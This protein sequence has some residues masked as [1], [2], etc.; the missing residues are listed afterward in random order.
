MNL[1]P[2]IWGPWYWGFLHTIAL[3]YPNNPNEVTKKKYY[4]LI[5]NFMLFIPNINVGNDFSK[6]LD[7]YPVSPYLDSKQHFIQWMHFIHNK[8]NEK[9][10]K[11]KI[12]INDFYINYYEHYKPKHVKTKDFYKW[13]EKIIYVIFSICLSC[14]IVYLHNK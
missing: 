8:I 12:S 6:L 13:R 9:M 4:E 3:S 11:P 14:L 10:E 7:L 1:N 2:D 5:N